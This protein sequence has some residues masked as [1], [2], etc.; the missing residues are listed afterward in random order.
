MVASKSPDYVSFLGTFF[1]ACNET[2][3]EFRLSI[4]LLPSFH[5]CCYCLDRCVATTVAVA[6]SKLFN[7]VV[8]TF[9]S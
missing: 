9:T 3:H 6:V 8:V 5:L 4:L 2:L 7:F 1:A